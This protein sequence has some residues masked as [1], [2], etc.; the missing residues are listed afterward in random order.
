MKFFAPKRISGNTLTDPIRAEVFFVL[1]TAFFWMILSGLFMPAQC[2]HPEFNNYSFREGVP[3]NEVYEIFQDSKGFIWFATDHGVAKF[4]GFEMKPITVK[5]GLTDPVV[6]GITEDEK[7]RLWF[8]TYSGKLSILENGKITPYQWNDQLE[9]LV[10]NNLMYCLQPSHGRLQFSTERYI[11]TI[12]AQGKVEKEPILKN[13]LCIK[14]TDD[15]K[16]LYGFHGSSRFIKK[17]KINN[18]YFPI[19]P[20]DTTNHNKVISG[21]QDGKKTIITLNSDIYLFDG[22]ALK[23]VFTGRSSIISFSK[24][25]E[26]FYWVGY[27]SMGTD[28]LN[29]DNFTVIVQPALL[30]DKSITKVLAD[31]EGGMWFSSLEQGVFYTP[32]LKTTTINLKDK[33]RFAAFDLAH[34]VI[35]DYRGNVSVYEIKTGILLWKK[36]FEVPIRSLF[37]DLN[38]Q[39]WI[40]HQF[41][42]TVSL[43]NGQLKDTTNISYTNFAYESDSTLIAVG[44]LRLTR[45]SVEGKSSRSVFSNT[46]HLK[47]LADHSQIYTSGRTGLEIFDGQMNLIQK[48]KTLTNSKITSIIPF[49]NDHIF[50]GTIGNGFQLIN[51]KDFNVNSFN[52]E[53][54]FIANDIYFAQ[55]KDSLLWLSTEKGLLALKYQALKNNRIQFSQSVSDEYSNEKIN[56]FQVTDSSIWAITDYSIKIIPTG[57]AN[58]EVNPIFHYELVRPNLVP[59]QIPELDNKSSMQL[60]FGFISFNNQN[61]YARYRI[62]DDA[63]WTETS[64][65]IIDLQSISPG[66]YSLVIQFSMDKE[67]W[68]TGTILPFK[69]SPVWWNTWYFRILLGFTL[70]LGGFIIYSKR[71]ARY[72]ER[73]DYLGLINEQQRKLLKA[74][75]EATERERSRIAQ[76]LHDSIGMDLVSIKLMT[77]QLAKKVDNKDALEIQNQLQKTIS[78]IQNIIYGLTPSGL[79]LFGLSHGLENYLSMVRSNHSTSIDFTYVGE[80]VKD[81]QLGAMVFRIIQELV[82]NSIKHAQCTSIIIT[83]DVTAFIHITYQDNGKGFNAEIVKRGLGLSNIKSRVESLAGQL[84]FDSGSQGTH[85][86]IKLPLSKL[87][88][89]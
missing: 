11:G 35:G 37:I 24:D 60:K 28:K 73:N 52:T 89:A 55:I 88:I 26:G 13:E 18:R 47:L 84:T 86:I 61:I 57:S 74:E 48:P 83:I 19:Q 29:P 33:I 27:A 12:D 36:N 72:K 40:S 62:S 49:D 15:E 7:Q 25:K 82:T 64:S 1:I 54:N 4:D 3:S 44:G 41:T 51:K 21:L 63:G 20:T 23:K 87:Q 68:K 46:I 38:N 22:K 77:N 5:D 78:E 31:H 8:R 6:F 71:I 67:N 58:N 32:D 39:L 17:I 75:I 50:I 9:E 45:L 81:Q 79:K 85:Y 66:D 10:R 56:F 16:L 69:V 14:V 76:D 59:N 65:R 43:E 34:A 30:P 80:E 2:Q 53:K 42:S 70:L